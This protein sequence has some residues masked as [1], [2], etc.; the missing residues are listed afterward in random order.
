VKRIFGPV[1]LI[2]A[3]ILLGSFFSFHASEIIKYIAE[4]ATNAKSKTISNKGNSILGAKI[5]TR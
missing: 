3:F 2:I 1:A 5:S 4:L